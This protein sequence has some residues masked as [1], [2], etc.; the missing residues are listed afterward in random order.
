MFKKY[1]TNNQNQ[2]HEENELKVS[3][4]ENQVPRHYYHGRDTTC[5]VV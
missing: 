2:A 3:V 5:G 1:D 4:L